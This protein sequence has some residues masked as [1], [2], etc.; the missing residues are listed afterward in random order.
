MSR[1]FIKVLL[2]FFVLIFFE[3]SLEELLQF[4]LSHDCLRHADEGHLGCLADVLAGVEEVVCQMTEQFVV[5]LEEEDVV[6]EGADNVLKAFADFE[7]VHAALGCHILQ[8]QDLQDFLLLAVL[9][10]GEEAFVG[11]LSDEVV[12]VRSFLEEDLHDW[13]QARLHD[14][15]EADEH[16]VERDQADAADGRAEGI[17]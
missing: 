12:G 1:L 6:P 5:L 9:D 16:L 14:A 10:Q 2:H 3:N 8:L 13:I 15:F 17:G 4:V 11:A 7:S